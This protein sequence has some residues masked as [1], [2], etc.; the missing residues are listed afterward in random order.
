MSYSVNRSATLRVALVIIGVL[1]VACLGLG[2][3]WS[4]EPGMT[5]R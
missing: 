3:Y 1:I 4:G 2:I 5:F